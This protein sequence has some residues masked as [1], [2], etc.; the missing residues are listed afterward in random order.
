MLLI[1]MLICFPVWGQAQS[2]FQADM[3]PGLWRFF[4]G[5]E[6]MGYGFYLHADGR[7]TLYDTDDYESFPPERLIIRDLDCAW[8]LEKDT[9]IFTI[10][11]EHHPFPLSFESAA[12][13][14]HGK[15]L[16]HL[17]DGDGGGSYQSCED[18]SVLVPLPAIPDNIL[19]AAS[20]HPDYQIEDYLKIPGTPMGDHA[21]LL[22]R[23]AEERMLL[24]FQWIDEEWLQFI[25]SSAPVPQG[26]LPASFHPIPAGEYER[27]WDGTGNFNYSADGLGFSIFTSSIPTFHEGVEF[28]WQEDGYHLVSYQYAP[29]C[30]VDLL[31]EYFVFHNIGDGLEG[32]GT[33]P[34]IT[35]LEYIQFDS[36]P[37]QCAE[38]T[39]IDLPAITM[40]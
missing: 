2:S 21:F 28:S 38:I 23:N 24:G 29:G 14:Y 27:L 32:V 26:Q 1:M 18:A 25:A 5:T 10:E 33:A 19:A 34:L 39:P 20:V 13:A 36:L 8:I 37:R 9:L 30:Y 40:E 35:N 22:I 3:L 31:G 16:I 12:T 15:E 11:R 6:V 4:G 7:A 17:A